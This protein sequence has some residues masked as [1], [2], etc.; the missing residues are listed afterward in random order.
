[1]TISVAHAGIIS[2]APRFSDIALSLLNL[3][4][5]IAA[6][7]AVIVVIAAGIMYVTAAGDPERIE[8]AK[9]FL[10]GGIIGLVVVI[11]SLTIV[12]VVSGLV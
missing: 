10:I 7:I 8:M 4:L 12:T 11:V 1:M 5:S 9:K 6:V 3:L 2:D